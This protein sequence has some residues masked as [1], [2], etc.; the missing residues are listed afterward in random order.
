MKYYENLSLEDLENEIWADAYGFDGYYEVSNLGRIKSLR[1]LCINPFNG[2]EWYTK[3]IIRK[4]PLGKDGRLTCVFSIEGRTYSTNVSSL[5]YQSFN[6]QILIDNKKQCVCHLDKIQDNNEINNLSLKSITD[7]H[8]I[9]FRLGLLPHMKKNGEKRSEI[10]LALTHKTCTKCSHRKEIK[11]YEYGR[12]TCIECRKIQ[13]DE[14]Y[15]T[16]ISAKKNK[17]QLIIQKEIV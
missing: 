16:K 7:S 4:Q 14:R 13:R 1:R 5:I 17:K 2:A 11:Y 8:K 12:N 3:E 6:P 10:Y 9:N 15:F